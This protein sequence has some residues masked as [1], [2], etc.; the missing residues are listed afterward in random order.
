[1]HGAVDKNAT[2]SKRKNKSKNKSGS[3]LSV[4][5]VKVTTRAL[6]PMP[7]SVGISSAG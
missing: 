3:K 7:A 5:W 6:S 2:M 1:M 4:N